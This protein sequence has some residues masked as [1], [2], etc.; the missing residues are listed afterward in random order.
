LWQS[1]AAVQYV[2][3]NQLYIKLVGS[4]SRAHFVQSGVMVTSYDD[5]NYSARL[6]FSFYF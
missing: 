6:R 2:M 4:Y 3:F 5:E 1:F